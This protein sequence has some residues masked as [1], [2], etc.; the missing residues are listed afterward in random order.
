MIRVIVYLGLMTKLRYFVW[1]NNQ[2]FRICSKANPIFRVG[3]KLYWN[4]AW[5]SWSCSDI[6][7]EYHAHP[8]IGCIDPFTSSLIPFEPV[9]QSGISTVLFVA[10]YRLPSHIKPCWVDVVRRVIDLRLIAKL[11]DLVRSYCQQ[12][13]VN[14]IA[15]T[16]LGISSKWNWNATRHWR[17]GCNI[18]LEYHAHLFIGDIDPF[19]STLVPLEPVV[20]SGV[21][22]SFKTQGYRGPREVEPGGIDMIRFH[23][24]LRGI[25]PLWD[26]VRI[27]LENVRVHTVAY[28]ILR[29]CPEVE[30]HTTRKRS[31]CSNVKGV[32]HVKLFTRHIDP[33]TSAL[34]PLEP[35]KYHCVPACL[36]DIGN[37]VPC[38]IYPGRV[39]MICWGVYGRHIHKLRD[40]VCYYREDL[41][42]S[43]KADSV[44]CSYSE[45]LDT[46]AGERFFN[47]EIKGILKQ[48][49]LEFGWEDCPIGISLIPRKFIINGI[50][51]TSQEIAFNPLPSQI[52]PSR[53]HH[54]I[55]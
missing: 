14:T 16:I 40:L 7:F 52:Y 12:I 48:W 32:D 50:I 8:F 37:A 33:F 4:S 2:D 38:H 23:I 17:W 29:I 49:A 24:D 43:S 31:N 25:A 53:I 1:C 34:V 10:R 6:D 18:E 39:N 35:V 51:T 41:R 13:W 5:Q 21:S 22:T 3:P 46:S 20:N 9:V 19:P 42:V 45:L 15:D 28:S 54:V 11:R 36:N 30:R 44:L 47:S 55:S 27:D 26:T